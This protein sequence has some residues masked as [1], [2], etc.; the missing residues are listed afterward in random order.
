LAIF[1]T[2]E[3][4]QT[5]LFSWLFLGSCHVIHSRLSRTN[6]AKSDFVKALQILQDS[7]S[8]T[9]KKHDQHDFY[10]RGLDCTLADIVIVSTLIYPFQMA[11]DRD[12]LVQQ[13]SLDTVVEWFERC[14]QRPEFQAVLGK[15]E[16]GSKVPIPA[17]STVQEVG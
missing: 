3:T 2:L 12:Y 15:V 5:F 4:T 16:I 1:S 11:C 6:K 13:H 9:K 17:P 7:L 8:V 14:V 10:L